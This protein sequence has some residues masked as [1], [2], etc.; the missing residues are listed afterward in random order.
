MLS[1]LR[2][3]GAV[4][5]FGG[6]SPHSG[7]LE[8]LGTGIPSFYAWIKVGLTL[9]LYASQY[10]SLREA[11]CRIGGGMT[12]GLGGKIDILS[13]VLFDRTKMPKSTF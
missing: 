7:D 3:R 6:L 12:P 13:P 10:D 4:P 8:G 11:Y 9:P 5:Q 1:E 2:I